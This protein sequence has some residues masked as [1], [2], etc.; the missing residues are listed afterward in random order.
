MVPDDQNCGAAQSS[1]CSQ[2]KTPVIRT[3]PRFEKHRVQTGPEH[4]AADRRSKVSS[5]ES[6][7]IFSPVRADRRS[8]QASSAFV[9]LEDV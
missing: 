5:S 1:G 7:M 6:N 4:G 8:T 3:R 2:T 9:L